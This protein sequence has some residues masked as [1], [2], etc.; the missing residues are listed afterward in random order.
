[1]TDL[2]PCPFCGSP[3]E[4]KVAKDVPVGYVYTPRCT[5]TSCAGRIT[6][7]WK[8]EEAAVEA[9]NRRH[10]MEF[11]GYIVPDELGGFYE[12]EQEGKQ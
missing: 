12:L 9:W 8:K 7:L 6:K 5:V 2:K 1:M 3:A 10:Y 11:G 4:M